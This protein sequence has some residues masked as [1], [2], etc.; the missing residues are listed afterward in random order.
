MARL[1]KLTEYQQFVKDNASRYKLKS[2]AV[3]LKAIG[4]LWRAKTGGTTSTPKPKKKTRTSTRG[5]VT[6]TTKRTTKDTV[7]RTRKTAKQKAKT[8]AVPVSGLEKRTQRLF[9]RIEQVRLALGTP[10]GD[11]K[12]NIGSKTSS[13][14]CKP[15]RRIKRRKFSD[16]VSA[17]EKAARGR[18]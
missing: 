1:A 10:R 2:G 6:V 8:Q 17:L 3:D 12:I 11:C 4:K 16:A 13:I 5:A 15:L 7:K 18:I 14:H 9:Q